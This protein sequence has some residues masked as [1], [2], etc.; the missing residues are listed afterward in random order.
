MSAASGTNLA[1][2]SREL[3]EWAASKLP[4]YMVPTTVT[5]L[6]KF[7]LTANGKL[8]R[9]ALPEPDLAE[10]SAHVAARNEVEQQFCTLIASAVGLDSVGVTDDFFALGGDSIVAISLV[11]AARA[12]GLSISPREV[13]QLRTAEAMARAQSGRTTEIVDHADQPIGH[14]ATTP[15]AA[16]VLGVSDAV[17]TFHQRALIQTP[18]ALT[19][20]H[21][22]SALDALVARHDALRATLTPEGRL[23]VPETNEA[24]VVF[25]TRA[26]PAPLEEC[27]PLIV[28]ETERAVGRLNPAAGTMVSAVLFRPVTGPGRLLLVIHHVV[29]DG[30][31]WR[32]ILEDLA[33]AGIAAMNGDEP[34]LAPVGTSVRRYA[35]LVS[36]AV[37]AGRLDSEIEFW[38]SLTSAQRASLGRRPLDPAVDLARTAAARSITLPPELADQ[39]LGSV[40][41]AF[42]ADV[43]E[44]LV[45][46]LAVA[47]TRW[48]GAG[49]VTIDLEGHGRDEDIV[50][51]DG[52]AHVDL[53]RTVGWFTT[54]FPVALEIGTA[55]P[56]LDATDDLA[57][58]L[59]SVK[60]QLRRVPNAGF[61]YG[62]LRY[63]GSSDQLRSFAAPEVVLNYLGRTA[64]AEGDWFPVSMDGAADPSMPL[65]HA[66]SVDVVVEDA[67]GGPRLRATLTWASNIFLRSDIDRFARLWLDSLEAVSGLAAFGGATPSDYPLVALA[68]ADVDGLP[69]AE[70]ILPLTPLQEGI[71]FHSA[72]ADP[73]ADQYVVQQVVELTG[74]VDSAALRRALQSV[75][76]RHEALRTGFSVLGDGRVVQVVH[77]SAVVEM[78][79]VE[80]AGADVD[81]LLSADRARGFDLAQPP[82]VRYALVRA[83][84]EKYLL[85]QS[86]H[87]AVADGWSVPVMLRELMAS[88]SVGD[89]GVVLPTPA[90]YRSYLEWLARHDHEALGSGVERSAEL[91]RARGR[92]SRAERGQQRS[93]CHPS[94]AVRQ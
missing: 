8:D 61:G 31:S 63:L 88:Y 17:R 78:A 5:V 65:G 42:G 52:A 75:V 54:V 74:A 12:A 1:I 43:S 82:L 7:P 84:S 77:P 90:P 49:S 66:L 83:S 58:V 19:S 44:V 92:T 20:E 40:P 53:T 27:G 26:L 68:Q 11:T 21:V 67:A 35:E 32:I 37:G 69:K 85:L 33:R 10:L 91:S 29:V 55:A 73:G 24:A 28:A 60:E 80:V 70:E 51:G 6:D 59:K 4:D 76:D 2:D 48:S 64:A 89:S 25:E 57:G 15:I 71:Y 3:R 13:F 72:F 30:V 79:V 39:L 45:T 81:E 9:R 23:L 87:H 41:R 18:S 36:E 86:I 56:D 93:L 50:R 62:A 14:V 46:A 22:E 16:R 38:D 94:R 34:A 47:L